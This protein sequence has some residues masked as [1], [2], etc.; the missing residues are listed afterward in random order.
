[1]H[2]A[3]APQSTEQHQFQVQIPRSSGQ[4]C[5]G[6]VDLNK[7]V[8]GCVARLDHTSWSPR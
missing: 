7:P 4:D 6:P 8:L 5:Q 1:M 3:A 2:I